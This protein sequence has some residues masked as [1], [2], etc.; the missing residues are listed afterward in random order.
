MDPE[1]DPVFHTPSIL[2]DRITLS[3]AQKVIG[4]SAVITEGTGGKPIVTVLL[5]ISTAPACESA[6][7]RSVAPSNRLRAP[8]ASIV[9]MNKELTPSSTAPFICQYTLHKDAPLMSVILDK[10]VVD[11]A[12]LI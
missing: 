11:S 9:P 1:R 12:P 10:V 3:P 7:P 8:F 2:P 6:L 5:C 4:P